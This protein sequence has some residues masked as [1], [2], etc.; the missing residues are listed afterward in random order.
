MAPLPF[1][2]H[3]MHHLCAGRHRQLRLAPVRYTSGKSE[4]AAQSSGI[5][6]PKSIEDVDNGKILGF[7]ADLSEDHPVSIR[8]QT[9]DH[10]AAVWSH[11]GI[12]CG[13]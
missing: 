6:I 8:R 4:T 3:G 12:C 5:K 1:A 7:G 13:L 9:I 11:L 10:S 2:A